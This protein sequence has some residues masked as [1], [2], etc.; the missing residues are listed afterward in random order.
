[1]T[2]W[3]LIQ[4][5]QDSG[6]L[7]ASLYQP[8]IEFVASPKLGFRILAGCIDDEALDGQA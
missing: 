5:S 4:T 1:M 6:P 8:T 7:G 3:T 2:L